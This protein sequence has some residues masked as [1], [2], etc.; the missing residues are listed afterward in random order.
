MYSNAHIEN[1]A[2]TLPMGFSKKKKKPLS[3]ALTGWAECKHLIFA[4]DQCNN[5]VSLLL[6]VKLVLDSINSNIEPD[7]KEKKIEF[8]VGHHLANMNG[9]NWLH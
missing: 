2:L 9:L 7:L 4:L 8:R 5:R 6:I 1:L 3:S